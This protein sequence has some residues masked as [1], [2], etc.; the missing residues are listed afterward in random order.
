[1]DRL[2]MAV[3]LIRE[4]QE[5]RVKEISYKKEYDKAEEIDRR[6]QDWDYTER[7]KVD[8]K[9]G[10]ILSK[11]GRNENLKIARRILVDEYEK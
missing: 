2:D 9:Y 11:Y 4:V 5:A 10:R 1:M 3:A 6:S 7:S 8:K